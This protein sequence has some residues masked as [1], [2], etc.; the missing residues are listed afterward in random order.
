M[1]VRN[2][3][4][5][6]IRAFLQPAGRRCRSPWP[7]C[8]G[9]DK[10]PPR[11]RKR[12]LGFVSQPPAWQVLVWVKRKKMNVITFICPPSLPQQGW[13]TGCLVRRART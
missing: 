10:E 1:G 7:L 2:G 8:P 9:W 13:C 5:K 4:R 6:S 11:V 12:V 3:Q